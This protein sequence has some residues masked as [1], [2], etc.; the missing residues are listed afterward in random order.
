MIDVYLQDQSS[1]FPQGKTELLGIHRTVETTKSKQFSNK[2]QFN[3]WKIR[4]DEMF[5]ADNNE[6]LV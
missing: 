2:F 3:P 1:Y 4:M 5:V 6:S